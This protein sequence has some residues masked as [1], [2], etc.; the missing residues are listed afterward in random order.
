LNGLDLSLPLPLPWAGMMCQDFIRR[1]NRYFSLNKILLLE[2][3]GFL[4]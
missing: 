3:S 1:R 4:G 2:G